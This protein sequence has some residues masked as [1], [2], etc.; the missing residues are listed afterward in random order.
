[1]PPKIQPWDEPTSP[2]SPSNPATTAE[3]TSE[4]DGATPAQSPAS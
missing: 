4:P 3:P 2:D 1:M